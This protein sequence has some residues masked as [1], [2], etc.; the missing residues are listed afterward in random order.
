MITRLGEKV[1]FLREQAGMSQSELAQELGL[2]EHSKGFISEIESGKKTPR[3]ELVLKLA[4][5]FRVT[6]DFLLRDEEG[7]ALDETS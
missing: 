5:I 2:S 1:R 3:A 4:N 6:T 7:T